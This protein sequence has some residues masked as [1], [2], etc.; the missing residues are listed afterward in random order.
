M[1]KKYPQHHAG[2]RVKYKMVR[3]ESVSV[4]DADL[5]CC[6]GTAVQDLCFHYI[7]STTPLLPKSEIATL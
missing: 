7:D 5:L 3:F 1:T 6:D 4:L 2:E